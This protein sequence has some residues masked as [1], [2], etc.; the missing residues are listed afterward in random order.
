M[1]KG[2]DLKPHI[3]I[4]GRRN[5]GKSSFINVLT[6]QDV[7]IVSEHP[8][9][10]TD[11]VR[12]S[13]EI[14]GI[15]P[16]IMVDTA[17]IDDTGDLGTKRIQKSLQALKTVDCAVLVIAGNRFG[18]FELQLISEFAKNDVPFIIIHNKA[19]IES[20]A[21]TTITDIRK[22][23][24]CDVLDFSASTKLG[25]DA[26]VESLRKNVPE[27]TYIFDSLIGDLVEQGDYVL[28]V[29][30]IDSEAP[31]GRMIL[32]QQMAIRDIL[33][34]KCI[35]ITLRETELEHFFKTSGIRPSLV[36]TDSQA[37]GYVK[38][39][40]PDDIPLTGFS[41]VFSRMKGDFENYIK[42]T[43][44]INDLRDGDKILILESC[45]H[46]ISCEDIGRAKIPMW[47]SKY[48]GKR[49]FFTNISGLG[50]L[51]ENY[52]EY[53]LVIQCGGCMVTRKQVLNRLKPFTDNEV[54]ITN[55][56]MVIA[57]LNGIFERVL[58]P[59]VKE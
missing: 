28:L 50:D 15:G 5:N 39:I 55:Y 59:F 33:D 41:I 1:I 30:P 37:F 53:K 40:V 24:D 26:V 27:K 46:H 45:T 7:A 48:T 42:G 57:Y 20:L 22:H 49:L 3:G 16:V 38:D 23:S 11:P 10:T 44:S 47:L 9:T 25:F 18:S 4:F 29:T 14:F 32:P 36:I 35:C 6:G 13:V 58:Q 17:G 43:R 52:R 2:K 34:N 54:S 8:G 51:P 21:Q 56:G 31:E 19:D 12:K